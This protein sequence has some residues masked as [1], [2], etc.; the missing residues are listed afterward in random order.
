[1]PKEK[2]YVRKVVSNSR[3]KGKCPV[4][5]VLTRMDKLKIYF[6]KYV[7]WD[8]NG[9]VSSSACEPSN[10]RYKRASTKYQRHTDYARTK[11]IK[12]DSIPSFQIISLVKDNKKFLKY[13]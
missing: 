10:P 7:L 3:D 6:S 9:T 5:D 2:T 11:N 8:D 1:M 12:S 13:Q 4:C